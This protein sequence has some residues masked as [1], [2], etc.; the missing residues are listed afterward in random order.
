MDLASLLL[1]H[2]FIQVKQYT[3][4]EQPN[5]LGIYLLLK[6][7]FTVNDECRNWELDLCNK[8][9]AVKTFIA[10]NALLF[11][12]WVGPIIILWTITTNMSEFFILYKKF[13]FYFI[14]KCIMVN[15]RCHYRRHS[16]KYFFMQNENLLG[17]TC[18]KLVHWWL[19]G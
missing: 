18:L 10:V 11:L 12:A 15:C 7:F 3:V 8:L 6:N 14:F 19:S 2:T 16:F 17:E 9:I 4:Q 1:L 13:F 5:I